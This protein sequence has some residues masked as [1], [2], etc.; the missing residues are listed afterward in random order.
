MF[1]TLGH[2]DVA[3]VWWGDCAGGCHTADF[4]KCFKMRGTL[5][6]VAMVTPW[7]TPYPAPG[8]RSPRG[9]AKASIFF[10]MLSFAAPSGRPQSGAGKQQ[11]PPNLT[12]ILTIVGDPRWLNYVPLSGQASPSFVEPHN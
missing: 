9:A 8:P 5:R 10:L 12:R 11:M 3:T 4:V 7:T 1:V 6:T 2:K